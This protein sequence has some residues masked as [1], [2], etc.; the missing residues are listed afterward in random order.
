LN[1]I[2]TVEALVI[3]PHSVDVRAVEAAHIPNTPAI[4]PA[5]K[6]S[7]PTTDSDVVK[8]DFGLRRSPY[9]DDVGVGWQQELAALGR[10]SMH[11]QKCRSGRKLTVDSGA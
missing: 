3:D 8:E 1:L 5:S 7:V 6:L 9:S 11:D 2:A 10:P 4:S